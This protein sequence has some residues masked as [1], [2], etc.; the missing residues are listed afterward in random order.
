MEVLIGRGLALCAHPTAAWRVLRAPGRAFVVVAYAAA[1]YAAVL[2]T[3][4]LAR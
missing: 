3:L 1:A 4:L 2:G